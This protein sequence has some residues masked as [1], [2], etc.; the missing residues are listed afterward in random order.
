MSG[1]RLLA[2]GV[3]NAFS[4]RYYSSCFALEAEGHW[5]LIDCPHP[6]RKIFRE[7]TEAA[8]LSLRIEDLAALA[9]THL[10]GDH[11]SGVEG[12][13]FFYRFVLERKPKVLAHA[14]V[15]A[16]LWP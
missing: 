15:A 16:R 14:D 2:L 7:G 13:L 9:L 11:A 12:F 10:H 8:G 5:L 3:G 1:M 4:A 6:I